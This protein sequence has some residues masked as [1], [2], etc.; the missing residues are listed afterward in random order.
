MN[1]GWWTVFKDVE[2]KVHVGHLRRGC[3]GRHS[4]SKRASL[5][6]GLGE[7]S[8]E[9]EMET[10]VCGVRRFGSLFP[11]EPQSLNDCQRK[12]SLWTGRKESVVDG[13]GGGGISRRWG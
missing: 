9:A 4:K 6:N 13:V 1:R 2:N 12:R 11:Q 3:L 8:A 10:R 7:L 5:E